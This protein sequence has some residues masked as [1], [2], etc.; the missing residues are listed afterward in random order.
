MPALASN[1]VGQGSGHAFYCFH[2]GLNHRIALRLPFWSAP[3]RW[4][5]LLTVR[6]SAM[7][8]WRASDN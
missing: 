7:T 4:L 5:L 3:I 2:L 6:A 8:E 1:E